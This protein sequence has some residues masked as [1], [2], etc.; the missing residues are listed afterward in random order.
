MR[1]SLKQKII[2]VCQQKIAQKGE[3]VGL[4]FYAFLP[5]AMTIPIC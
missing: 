3:T 4:S 1:A 2:Q 5:I